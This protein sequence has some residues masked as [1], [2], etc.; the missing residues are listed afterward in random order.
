VA[1]APN[2][3]RVVIDHARYWRG[4]PHVWST[5]YF[6]GGG[7]WASGE[8]AA[9]VGSLLGMESAILYNP[10]ANICGFIEARAYNAVTGAPVYVNNIGVLATPS[11]WDAYSGAAWSSV[12]GADYVSAAE[13]CFLL[14]TPLAG[15]S[16]TGKPVKSTKYFHSVGQL[17]NEGTTGADI[18]AAVQTQIASY[19]AILNSGVGPNGRRMIS[20]GGRFPSGAPTVRP[21]FGN[22]QMPQGRRKKATSGGTVLT[23]LIKLV[24]ENPELAGAEILADA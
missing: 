13:V 22:H 11:T 9:V 14:D 3:P 19:T 21:F 7:A 5:T 24:Q 12:T 2:F 8:A 15:L 1:T 4:V 10:G 17:F 23:R 18:P 20:N 6:F 16:S